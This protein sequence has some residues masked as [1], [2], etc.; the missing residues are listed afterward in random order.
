VRPAHLNIRVDTADRSVNSFKE[1]FEPHP[2]LERLDVRFQYYDDGLPPGY[3][4]FTA[5]P[6]MRLSIHMAVSDKDVYIE[7]PASRQSP[8]A[9]SS[10]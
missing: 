2:A 4:D 7:D 5:H 3:F 6:E 10:S 8:S 9:F 1:I